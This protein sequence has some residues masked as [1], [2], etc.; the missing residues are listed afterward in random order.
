MYLEPTPKRIRV[1]VGGETIADSRRAFMLH[2]SGPSPSIT[3]R[4]RTSV[5]SGSSPASGTRI[6]Q[7]RATPRTTRSRRDGETVEAAAWSYPE[8]LPDAPAA[9]K[10]LIAFYFNRM[11]RW[12]RRPRRSSSTPA[13]PTTGST[14]WRPTGA[15]GCSGRRGPGRDDPGAGPVR[16]Q[17]AAPLVPTRA[18]T[19]RSSLPVR[20]P[21][22]VART[23]ARPATT[24]SLR[25]RGEDV[26]W[27]Y[28]DPLPEVARI[29]G[30]LCFF[31]ERGGH[32]AR[33][34]A[35]GAARVTVEPRREVRGAGPERP[36]GANP[37]L[38]PLFA[39]R[40]NGTEL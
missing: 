6:A 2:E 10:G 27:Y 32:R 9:L 24:R 34:G 20:T 18:R 29:K 12:L 39:L 8:P 25:G 28:A 22:P 40:A 15:S 21:S 30:R 4:P 33:R 5:L 13:I 19:S 23:K 11:G 36:A 38:A 3:S 17:P 35:A 26:V 14:W 37:R 31:N 1:E 16:V 7:R